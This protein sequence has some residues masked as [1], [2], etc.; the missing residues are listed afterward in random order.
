MSAD[1]HEDL[2]GNVR[3]PGAKLYGAECEA[4]NSM[5]KPSKRS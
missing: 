1:V 3:S 4:P 5:R 2:D